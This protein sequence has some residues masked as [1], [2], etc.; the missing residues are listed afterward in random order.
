MYLEHTGQIEGNAM[1]VLNRPCLRCS[2][3]SYAIGVDCAG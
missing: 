1:V 3:P 2:R